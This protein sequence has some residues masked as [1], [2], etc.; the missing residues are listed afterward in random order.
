MSSL[1][2]DSFPVMLLPSAF[3]HRLFV[4][5]R[6]GFSSPSVLSESLGLRV[7]FGFLVLFS[8]VKFPSLVIFRF[9]ILLVVTL[10]SCI[11]DSTAFLFWSLFGLF[12][13]HFLF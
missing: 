1:P 2:P 7:V 3:N 12:F 8:S 13:S 11:L 10:V 4:C 5:E 6:D 9:H